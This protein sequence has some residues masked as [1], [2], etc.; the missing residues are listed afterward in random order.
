MNFKFGLTT[1]QQYQV[2]ENPNTLLKKAIN[3]LLVKEKLKIEIIGALGGGFQKDLNKTISEN[4]INNGDLVLLIVK[5]DSIPIEKAVTNNRQSILKQCLNFL[6]N[7]CK[8]PQYFFDNRGNCLGDWQTGR[9]SGPKGYL[10]DYYP[11]IGWTGIG[12]KA[13][14][15]YDNGDNSWIGCNNSDGEWYIAYHG[16]KS[17]EALNGI[18]LNGFRRGEYQERAS[19]PN[20]NPLTNRMYQKCGEGVYFIQNFLETQKYIAVFSYL[21]NNYR[22]IFMCRVNPHKVRIANIGNNLESWIVNGDN[23]NDPNGRRRDD[24]VRIYRILVYMDNK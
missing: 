6:I 5:I 15:L 3:N 1:G 2:T 7:G 17:L 10:K 23:L 8:I 19:Y 12:L 13:W 20:M 4:E 22:I 24:E 21:G 14:G 11:P 16:I 9:K 18:L